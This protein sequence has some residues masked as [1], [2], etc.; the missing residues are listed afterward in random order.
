MKS[1]GSLP[2]CYHFHVNLG[3]EVENLLSSAS[4]G[5][6]SLPD[7]SP[8]CLTGP[9]IKAVQRTAQTT[10]ATGP[11]QT[12]LQKAAIWYSPW[13]HIIVSILFCSSNA[14]GPRRRTGTI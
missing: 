8:L 11:V 12:Y 3:K 7:R 9:K 6:K 4:R 14:R 10:A 2:P 5:L 13:S 1:Q